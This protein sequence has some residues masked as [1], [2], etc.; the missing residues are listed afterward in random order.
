VKVSEARENILNERFNMA[1]PPVVMSL[2]GGKKRPAPA[3]GGNISNHIPS[4]TSCCCC[5]QS[6]LPQVGS[7]VCVYVSAGLRERERESE[8]ITLFYSIECGVCVF[9]FSSIFYFPNVMICS[10]CISC[11]SVF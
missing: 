7:V 2:G 4:P 10:C 1:A 6:W 11:V 5:C 8:S 9:V 3:A